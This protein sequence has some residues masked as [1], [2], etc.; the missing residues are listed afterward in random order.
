[1]E[2]GLVG[3]GEFVGSLGQ[4]A[5][6][7][8]A[9]DAAFDGVALL[10]GFGVEVGWPAAELA[11]SSTMTDLVGGL[12]DGGA[13]AAVAKMRV[14]CTGGIRAVR[15][16]S[17]GSGSGS[18]RAGPWNPDSGHH[19]FDCRCIAGLARG[20]DGGERTCPAI[21]GQ[22]D[23]GAGSAMGASESV[24]DGFASVGRPFFPASAACW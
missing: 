14:D 22:V 15:E 16:N 9:V 13:G 5:L 20:D 4:V 3:D 24:I 1:M 10:V 12:W 21:A 18:S 19:G 2:C 8:E 23:L 17:C 7:F 11:A 6:L